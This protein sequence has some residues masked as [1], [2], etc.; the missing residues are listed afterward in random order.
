MGEVELPDYMADMG[1]EYGFPVNRAEKGNTTESAVLGDMAKIPVEINGKKISL[2][3]AAAE[4]AEVR[5]IKLELESATDKAGAIQKKKEAII[6]D[7]GI[8]EATPMRVTD[9]ARNDLLSHCSGEILT[10]KGDDGETYATAA[11][12][13]REKYDNESRSPRGETVVYAQELIKDEYWKS[14]ATPEETAKLK[15]MVEGR[16]SGEIKALYALAFCALLSQRNAEDVLKGERGDVRD[17]IVG[18]LGK[19]EKPF[20]DIRTRD[21]ELS[22]AVVSAAS[23]AMKQ[24]L[25][26]KDDRELATRIKDA[27]RTVTET[28]ADRYSAKLKKPDGVTQ[29]HWEK[30]QGIFN[31]V[32]DEYPLGHGPYPDNI[33]NVPTLLRQGEIDKHKQRTTHPVGDEYVALRNATALLQEAKSTGNSTVEITGVLMMRD[34]IKKYEDRIVDMLRKKGVDAASAKTVA[35]QLSAGYRGIIFQNRVKA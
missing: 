2:R 16:S 35:E 18:I 23:E 25:A 14:L 9:H 33:N 29:Q 5:K 8:I 12:V 15:R 4:T 31:K 21:A 6:K 13:A 27:G 11:G 1:A 20:A 26:N 10:V 22:S 19:T 28:A 32:V 7:I 3:R 24:R 17:K 30:S 34:A